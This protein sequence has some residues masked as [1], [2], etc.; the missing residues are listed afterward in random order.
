MGENTIA[1]SPGANARLSA[2]VVVI[3]GSGGALVIDGD[4]VVHVPAPAV[5]VAGRSTTGWGAQPALP[6]RQQVEAAR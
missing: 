1:V 4:H 3:L 2:A 6:T 5:E